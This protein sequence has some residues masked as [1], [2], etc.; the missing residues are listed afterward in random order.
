LF[1]R[2]SQLGGFCFGELRIGPPWIPEPIAEET[3]DVRWSMHK[4]FSNLPLDFQRR[5][6]IDESFVVQLHEKVRQ[7]PKNVRTGRR[8][9]MF[10]VFDKKQLKLTRNCL[11]SSK[12]VQLSDDYH[13]FIALDPIAFL[14]FRPM[15][16]AVLFLNLSARGF[17]YFQFCRVKLFIQ[18]LLLFWN[19]EATACDNDLVFLRNPKELFREESDCEATIQKATLDYPLNYPWSVVNI[20]FMRVLPSEFAITVYQQWLIRAL[21]RMGE[22]SQ[23]A[24]TQMLQGRTVYVIQSTVW[25]NVSGY[26]SGNQLFG[27]RYY[28]PLLV[29][30]GAMM[31][32]MVSQQGIQARQRNITEPYI[33]HLA[34]VVPREKIK[35]FVESG[36]WFLASDGETCG[37]IPDKRLYWEW[38]L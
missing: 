31:R 12:S 21:V 36:L 15:H 26:V 37:P 13:I 32:K 11:C 7:A 8:E 20:G 9:L 14:A 24:L 27:L 4:L 2:L 25:F 28:D 38:K 23:D 18:L 17:A 3:F 30:N 5:F 1:I 29:Q 33:C 35:V 22:L 19:V 16:P 6:W 34:W 10:T